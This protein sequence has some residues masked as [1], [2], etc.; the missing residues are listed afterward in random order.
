MMPPRARARETKSP[1]PNRTLRLPLTG[2]SKKNVS[3]N[4]FDDILAVVTWSLE[5]LGNGYWPDRRHDGRPWLST[6]AKRKKH[7]TQQLGCR[8]AL[9]EVRGDWKF[10]K[11]VFYLP[12]WN[13]KAGCCWRCNCTPQQIRQ[14]GAD[15][16]WRQ[17]ENRMGHWDVVQRI[18]A[19]GKRPSPLWGAPWV[20]SSIFKIDW[21]HCAD[22]GVTADFLANT[23]LLIMSRL[24]GRSNKARCATLWTRIQ[25][26]YAARGVEDRLT[27]LT[28][29]MIV[30]PKKSPKLRGSAAQCRALVPIVHQLASDVLSS[31]VPIEE[32]C[33]VGIASL[34]QCYMALSSDSIFWR[35]ILDE[36]SRRFAAQYVAL[37]AAT[38]HNKRWVV[39]PKLH[40]F[41][42]LCSSGEKPSKFWAYRDEDFGGTC[43]H[44]ARRRGGLLRPS[45]TSASMLR[46]FMVK[47][48]MPRI[49]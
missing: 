3:E 36:H 32:A 25:E 1:G 34:N 46:K 11:E 47:S 33:K 31:A 45:A 7:A 29:T 26:L 41:L 5:Q 16:A 19:N 6:D 23:M 8:G 40:L 38:T 27:G 49:R 24:D 12:A 4:T 28:Y 22:H 10:F 37:E 9:V 43:A 39:K 17:N 42:E 2:L 14:V 13:E 35:D 48:R 44:L 21:L 30:Q 15:A 18:L 20:T